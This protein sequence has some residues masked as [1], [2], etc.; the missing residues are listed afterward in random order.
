MFKN[1]E[2]FCCKLATAAYVGKLV[3]YFET[4]R[5]SMT[6]WLIKIILLISGSLTEDLSEFLTAFLHQKSVT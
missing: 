2:D 4:I 6:K 3:S 1:Q 5:I